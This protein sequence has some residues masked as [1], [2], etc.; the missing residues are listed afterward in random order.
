MPE[1]LKKTAQRVI[2][3]AVR[4]GAKQA[5]AWAELSRESQVRVRDGDVED[6]QQATSRGL[7]LRV[8]SA[9]RLGFAYTSDLSDASLDTLVD[10]ALQLAKSSAPDPSNR[11]PTAKELGGGRLGR[12]TGE[13]RR[14]EH[15]IGEG[16]LG[17]PTGEGRRPEHGIGEGRLGRPTGGGRRPEHGIVR[18]GDQGLLDPEVIGLS[19]EWKIDAAKVMERAGRAVDRHVKTFESVGASDVVAEVAIASSEGL[20]DSYKSSYVALYA[21]PVAQADDGQ[22]QT[23]YWVDYRRFLNELQPPEVVGRKAAERAVRMLGA[24]KGKTCRVPVVMEPLQAASF[25]GG[26]LSALDG[27]RIHQKAS[28]FLGKL[29]ERVAPTTLSLVDDGLY[30]RGLG[31]RPFDGEGLPTRRTALLERG[32]LKSYLY[33]TY[34]AHK[35]KAHSTATAGRGYQSLPHIGTTTVIVESTATRPP[36]E[37]LRGIKSGLYV[38]S[39]LGHG[40]DTVTGDYSQGAAGL[41]IENG[42]L[43]GPV[44]E[45]TVA[46]NLLSMLA[47][48]DAVGDDLD[49]R[50]TLGAPTIRFAELTVAGA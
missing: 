49:M 33:D 43:A 8:I 45:M 2:E 10:R 31:S 15:G 20:S 44:Q 24:K 16:R 3:R 34:T 29:G 32:V 12:P 22:L 30:P 35:A 40:A 11:L 26:L 48:I 19:T 38:T 41:W 27:K 13:G 39:M 14:P 46:G 6:L 17:R 7:G 23:G 5:D 21:A 28:F 1:D 9:G 18:H 25:F 4:R 37:I 36:A 42:E 50:G 47:S